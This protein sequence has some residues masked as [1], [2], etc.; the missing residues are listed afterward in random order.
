MA[1]NVICFVIGAFVLLL[2]VVTGVAVILIWR[3][4]MYRPAPMREYYD[5]ENAPRHGRR[6]RR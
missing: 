4:R 1:G 2:G 6:V 5:G 3:D